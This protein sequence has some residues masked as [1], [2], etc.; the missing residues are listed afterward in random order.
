MSERIQQLIQFI[1][2]DPGDPFNHYALALEY[3]KVDERKALEILQDL[4][5]R[6]KE[7]IPLYYQLAKLYDKFGQKEKA[8]QTFKE[9]MVIAREQNDIKT[10]RELSAGLDELLEDQEE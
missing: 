7:Y 3:G 6:H 10:F 5:K 8:I 9:G 4:L 2:E 1:A